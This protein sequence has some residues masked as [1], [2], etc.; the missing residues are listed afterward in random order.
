MLFD[1]YDGEPDR[2]DRALQ[3]GWFHTDDLGHV[4]ADGH[5]HIEG[6]GD[7]VII[8]G[9]VKVPARAVATALTADEAAVAVEVVGVP[10]D[11]W[12]ERVVAIVEARD[13]IALASL[14]DL[15]EP[16]SW[17][18]RQLVVVSEIPQ[19]TNGK[20]DRLAMRELAL[21]EWHG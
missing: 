12:G 6:R 21:R 18:P 20:P 2:T 1:G 7:D 9:G 19:L 3:G 11:E 10:D 14:R 16:R 4:D 17:A 15:V 13:P 8:S 5:L